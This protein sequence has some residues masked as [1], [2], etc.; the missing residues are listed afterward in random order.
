MLHPTEQIYCGVHVPPELVQELVLNGLAVQP[1]MRWSRLVFGW[2]SS[3]Y[4][5]L[6]MLARVLELAVETTGE[7]VFQIHSVVLNLP[8]AEGYDPGQP[9]VL[10]R[11]VDGTVSADLV[12]YFDDARVFGPTEVVAT[13]GLRQVTSRIQ[14]YGNQDA[15]RKRRKPSRQ[16]GAW[17][18][19]IVYTDQE[20]MRKLIS[21]EKWHRVKE[22]LSYVLDACGTEKEISRARFLSGVG[23]LLHLAQTYDFMQPHL[24]GF[25]LAAEAWRADRDPEGWKGEEKAI[26]EWDPDEPITEQFEGVLLCEGLEGKAPIWVAKLPILQ[27]DAQTLADFFEHP[28][29]VQVIVHPIQGAAYVAYGAGDASGEGFGSNIHPLGM[30]PLLQ[31]GFWCTEDSEQSLN[32]R[33]LRNLVA[34]VRVESERGRLVGQELWLATDNST[35]ALAYYKGTASSPKLHALMTELR[36]LTL[37]GNFVLSIFHIA[38][39]RMIEIGVDSL[40]RGEK[41]V[42]ALAATP[43]S[44]APLHLTPLQQSPTLET[45]LSTWVEGAFRVASPK[46]WF[47]DAQQMGTERPEE[48]WVWDLPPGAALT[49]LEELGTAR[50]KRHERLRGIV[51]VPQLL[52]N[53]W[54]RRFCRIVDF[55]FVIPAGAIPEWPVAMHKALT[56]G[57]YLPLCRYRPWSWK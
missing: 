37:T 8:R 40:S 45:W 22:F 44:A 5:A 9:R 2:Q 52:Q 38:R 18:G 7:N 17:A 19:G 41:H 47:Q 50:L 48:T 16:P 1:L 11:R 14:R 21:Q 31:H 57:L 15:G 36:A 30:Q 20:L 27:R 6:R 25:H 53:E 54:R 29:P 24:K 39:T 32:W 46:D 3:P 12:V 55:Y 51:I 26:D 23:F 13:L 4:L 56:V 34:A 42:G 35:A 43:Q 33:E 49:V 10:K 28:N